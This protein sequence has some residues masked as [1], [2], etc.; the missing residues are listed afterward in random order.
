MYLFFSPIV[1]HLSELDYAGS[2]ALPTPSMDGVLHILNSKIFRLDCNTDA[3]TWT[4]LPQYFTT[5]F[6]RGGW[7]QAFYIPEE[8]TSCTSPS[9]RT[10]TFTTGKRSISPKMAVLD[11][12]LLRYKS[13]ISMYLLTTYVEFYIPTYICVLHLTRLLCC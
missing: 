4:T 8:L 12:D 13:H 5:D 6:E 10:T 3:C 9:T 2:R 7:F 1:P 11:L